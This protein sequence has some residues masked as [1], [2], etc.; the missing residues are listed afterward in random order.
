MK[1]ASL[2]IT[3]MKCY[4]QNKST[5]GPFMGMHLRKIG[6]AVTASMMCSDQES[7]LLCC[8]NI[9]QK[10]DIILMTAALFYF[11]TI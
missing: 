9:W 11:L 8:F 2:L 4:Q 3:E 7:D 1:S 10:S 5:N 6:M